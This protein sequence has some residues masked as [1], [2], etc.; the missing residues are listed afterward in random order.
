MLF[1]DLPFFVLFALVFPLNFLLRGKTRIVMLLAASYTFYG[2]WDWRFLSLLAISTIVDYVVALLLESTAEQRRR[3]LILAISI[4]ANVGILGFFKYFNFFTDTFISAFGI[5]DSHRFF[6]E[7]ILPPGISFYTFQTMA[8]TI[9]VYRRR[10]RAE[11]SIL[12]FATYVAFFPQLIAGPIERPGKLIPQLHREPRFSW[13][14]IYYGLRLFILGCFKK[15]VIADNL[16]G[17]SDT[18]FADPSSQTSLGLVIAAYCFAIQ[19]Y[20][21]FSGYTDMAR[22]VAKMMGINLS[23][24]F[25]LPYWSRSLNEFWRRW[26]ITLS[27][28]LRDYVYIPLGGS[29]H[30]LFRHCRNLLITFS[31]SGLWHGASWTFVLWG[32]LHGS[33]IIGELLL[34]RIVR[35]RPPVAVQ[36]LLTF[37][38]VVLLWILFRAQTMPVAFEFYT[39]LLSPK[40]GWWAPADRLNA[41]LLVFYA[42]PLALF[43]LW[44]YRA[45]SL[46]PDLRAS[47]RIVHGLAMG[48]AAFFAILLG[49]TSGGQFIYFQF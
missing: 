4:A 18:A 12:T 27:F 39:N 36:I 34:S 33:W 37:H 5:S 20:C 17:I 41:Y 6:F 38:V 31:L 42:L 23:L 32:V 48:G 30:G 13:A 28:W 26:H 1:Y 45:N 7:V 49:A 15:L 14:N 43:Q 9:D 44:Q 10:T 29:R 21:D 11:R 16:A 47:N 35:W 40:S 25:N 24:N 19:I 22:G 46:T 3:K 2:W 8:Y